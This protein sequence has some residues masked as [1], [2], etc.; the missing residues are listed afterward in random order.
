MVIGIDE[1]GRGAWAGPLVVAAVGWPK[2][3]PPTELISQLNDSKKLSQQKREKIFEKI[4]IDQLPT[5]LGWFSPQAIDQF[6]LGQGLFQTFEK[7]FKNNPL[8]SGCQVEIIIDGPLN[9]LAGQPKSRALIKADQ[10]EPTVM[11]ASIVAKVVRDKFLNLLDQIYPGYG[12]QRHKGYGSKLHQEN[13]AKK[14]AVS[15][16]HRF[17]FQPI[18][19]TLRPN[20]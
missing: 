14:G 6:G 9:Y 10:I 20:S 7:A 8:S 3:K 2:E 17:S 13:L 16:L 1:S 12:L 18:A 4:K 15:G 11:A 19:K 5:G